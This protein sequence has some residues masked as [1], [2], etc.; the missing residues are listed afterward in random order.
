MCAKCFKF[1]IFVR[2]YFLFQK[3][4]NF[5]NTAC[6]FDHLI[7]KIS[8]LSDGCL[9]VVRLWLDLPTSSRRDTRVF[10]FKAEKSL[11]ETFCKYSSE[12]FITGNFGRSWR[13]LFQLS[14]ISLTFHFICH[15]NCRLAALTALQVAT[16][17]YRRIVF[18]CK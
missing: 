10:K 6:A 3:H 7:L 14:N 4:K 5:G 15:Q 12:I 13:K 17:Y 16:I 8:D 9:I 11:T 18:V 1:W 2:D